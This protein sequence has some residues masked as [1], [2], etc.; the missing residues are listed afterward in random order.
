MKD[1]IQEFE[2][3]CLEYEKACLT[4]NH[5]IIN[6]YHDHIQKKFNKIYQA[7]LLDRLKSLLSNNNEIVRLW[8][9]SKLLPYY[10]KE[11]R[12]VLEDIRKNSLINSSSAKIILDTFD[13]KKL[14]F[15]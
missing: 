4:N 1:L 7:N 10:E 3:Y 8:S 15:P 2:Y 11:S 14:T 6:K 13:G 9:S 12:I 5:K